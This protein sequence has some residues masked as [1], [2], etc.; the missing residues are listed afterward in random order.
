[1]AAVLPS[2]TG[3]DYWSLDDILA[4]QERVSC[5]VEQPLYRLGFLSSSN[6]EP[7]LH[8]NTKLELPLWLVKALCTRRRRIVSISYPKVYR[9]PM[10]TALL[11]DAT[12]IN[13]HYNGPYFF[14]FGI[15]LLCFDHPERGQLSQCLL[16]VMNVWWT[17][18]NVHHI[19]V[20]VQCGGEPRLLCTYRVWLDNILLFIILQCLSNGH[21]TTRDTFLVP[22]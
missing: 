20:L 4:G 1:M 3:E 9:E 5:K 16:E 6:S 14:S 15:K 7:H 19:A 8:P 12:S 2:G 13:L 17:S 18:I 10:R 21:L 11:A 22:F